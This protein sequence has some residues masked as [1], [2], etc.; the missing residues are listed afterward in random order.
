LRFAHTVVLAA[1]SST[2]TEGG[3]EGCW[4]DRGQSPAWYCLFCPDFAGRLDLADCCKCID[5]SNRL[6][7]SRAASYQTTKK[8]CDVPEA[9]SEDDKNTSVSSSRDNS[10]TKQMAHKPCRH[11][12]LTCPRKSS[13][14]SRGQ[15]TC[16]LVLDLSIPSTRQNTINPNRPSSPT[17]AE[18]TTHTP[19]PPPP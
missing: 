12:K 8:P 19:S 10:R 16:K 9:W 2:H 4:E 3:E 17:P 14:H 6:S 5:K 7:Q 1:P 11:L 15:A 18:Q 13:A